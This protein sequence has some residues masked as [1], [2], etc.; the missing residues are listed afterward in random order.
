V[1]VGRGG[2][3]LLLVKHFCSHD[4]H[5]TCMQEL[6]LHVGRVWERFSYSSYFPFD[7]DIQVLRQEGFQQWIQQGQPNHKSHPAPEWGHEG[8]H[9]AFSTLMQVLYGKL[10][11]ARSPW[12]R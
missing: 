9:D 8:G 1:G 10:E 5:A 7:L 6:Q 12:P 2:E 11:G 3:A 4:P